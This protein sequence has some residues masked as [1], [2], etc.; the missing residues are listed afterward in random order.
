M[1]SA[2]IDGIM[3]YVISK[4]MLMALAVSNSM[5]SKWYLYIQP[6]TV[7]KKGCWMGDLKQVNNNSNVSL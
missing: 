4:W 6:S 3:M 5:D 1:H 7:V 2:I